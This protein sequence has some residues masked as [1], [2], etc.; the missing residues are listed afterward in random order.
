MGSLTRGAPRLEKHV[1]FRAL[2]LYRV[3]VAHCVV[4]SLKELVGN[5]GLKLGRLVSRR[6]LPPLLILRRHVLLDLRRILDVVVGKIRSLVHSIEVVLPITLLRLLHLRVSL[7]L[8]E[9]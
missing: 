5:I 8:S 9:T 1:C 7:W 3:W 4:S 6:D 2:F